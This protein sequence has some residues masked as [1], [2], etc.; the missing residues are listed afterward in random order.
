MTEQTTDKAAAKPAASAPL[1]EPELV[2]DPH[3]VVQGKREVDPA[4]IVTLA[5]AE[6]PDKAAARLAESDA[7]VCPEKESSG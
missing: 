3:L 4:L 7:P 6:P 1:K 2:V 5:A